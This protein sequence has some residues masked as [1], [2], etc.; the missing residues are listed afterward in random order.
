MMSKDLGKLNHTQKRRFKKKTLYINSLI[1]TLVIFITVVSI[2][3]FNI[4]GSRSKLFNKN[5]DVNKVSN[6]TLRKIERKE[7]DWWDDMYGTNLRL[8]VQNNSSLRTLDKNTILSFTFDHKKLVD[9]KRSFDNGNDFEL[10]YYAKDEVYKKVAFNL[11]N[12]NS[13]KS[14]IFFQTL[15]DVPSQTYDNFYYLYLGNIDKKSSLDKRV[16]NP[17]KESS[18]STTIEKESQNALAAQLSRKWIIRGGAGVDTKYKKLDVKLFSTSSDITLPRVNILKKDN[19]IAKTF[20]L[21]YKD[22]FSNSMDLSSMDTGEYYAQISGEIGGKRRNSPKY[23]LIVSEPMFMN[24]SIDWEGFY[25]EDSALNSIENFSKTYNV[26]ITH[27]FNPRIYVKGQDQKRAEFLTNWIKE[28]QKKGDE[29]S[30]H[31]HMWFDMVQEAGVTVK[32][33]PFWEKGTEGHDVP[34][35]VYSPEEFDKL[36]TWGLEKFKVH[37]LPAPKGYRAGGWQINL[38]DLKVLE[39]NNFAYDSSGRDYV[40]FGAKRMAVPW[41]LSP[42]SKPY[43]PNIHNMNKADQPTLDILEFPNNGDNSSNYGPQSRKII[44]NFNKNYSGGILKEKQTFVFL[45]HVQLFKNDEPVI[46]KFFEEVQG[47]TA[48]KDNGPLIYTTVED[49]LP[50]YQ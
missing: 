30:L 26:P 19:S 4:F 11:V 46:K 42:T 8:K 27:Y 13:D 49:I 50:E 2:F 10:V 39:R 40:Q 3:S 35:T 23:N 22:S 7:G 15:E 18:F 16:V 37:G 17:S 38:D 5:S 44:D 32:K 48:D 31:L 28:R 24:W 20:D 34:T 21:T 45:S 14:E 29:I 33:E 41:T 1:V 9:D 6:T 43:R 25:I 47:K 36:V 12:P